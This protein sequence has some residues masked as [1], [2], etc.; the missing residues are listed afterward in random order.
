MARE[1]QRVAR[2]AERYWVTFWF[3]SQ[4]QGAAFEAMVLRAV[5]GD[6]G[7]GLYS[8]LVQGL[9]LELNTKLGRDC[10]PGERVLLEVQAARPR[11]GALFFRE[12]PGGVPGPGALQ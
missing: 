11:D 1:A 3:A 8:V 7:G 2:Q 4:P 10:A 5:R 12:R 6:A 9:G